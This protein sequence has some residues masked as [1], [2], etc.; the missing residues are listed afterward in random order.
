MR[1]ASPQPR[2]GP[3]A[4]PR[5]GCSWVPTGKGLTPSQPAHAVES[6][7]TRPGKRPEPG[8]TRRREAG[9]AAGPRP[10]QAA[11]WPDAAS[12]P[13]RDAKPHRKE[14]PLPGQVPAAPSSLRLRPTFCNA[15]GP[16][17]ASG[18]SPASPGSFKLS[19]DRYR[20]WGRPSNC[21][22]PPRGKRKYPKSTERSERETEKHEADRK[23]PRG[24]GG[25]GDRW[26]EIVE[27]FRKLPSRPGRAYVSLPSHA[28]T[29]ARHAQS[30]TIN[31]TTPN[32]RPAAWEWRHGAG[33]ERYVAGLQPRFTKLL[34]RNLWVHDGLCSR[35][36]VHDT[37]VLV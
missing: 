17:P 30:A 6:R 14:L 26:T 3:W 18:S 34:F 32:R 23:Y 1:G 8:R 9:E 37:M 33:G 19:S 25:G 31:C 35:V 5:A 15:S 10:Q 4:I 28:F 24:V 7:G 36:K 21:R 11:G 16:P 27:A 2:P 29:H 13:R 22:A 12:R 20:G